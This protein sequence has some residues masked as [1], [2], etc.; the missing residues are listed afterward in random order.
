MSRLS[1][2]R[3]RGS[4]GR[5]MAYMS[6]DGCVEESARR[7]D[8]G[9]G[10]MNGTHSLTDDA[11]MEASYDRLFTTIE[12]LYPEADREDDEL[13]HAVAEFASTH[14]N[15]FFRTGVIVGF[16]LYKELEEG[17]GKLEESDIPAALED[18][19]LVGGEAGRDNRNGSLHNSYGDHSRKE[20]EPLL[21][22]FFDARINGALEDSLRCDT[23]FQTARAGARRKVRKLQDMGLSSR[24]WRAVDQALSASNRSASEYGRAAYTLGFRDAVDVIV[25]L[26]GEA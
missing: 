8:E 9:S 20:P 26:N 2:I 6:G 7:T 11:E 25:E 12:E 4:L 3:T 16:R 14:D 10:G 21:Q 23:R 1:D 15:A 17:Y 18:C 13:F 22:Q 5:V 24:Q 19:G